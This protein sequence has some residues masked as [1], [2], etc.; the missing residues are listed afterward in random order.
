MGQEGLCHCKK[1]KLLVQVPLEDLQN[2]R[3]NKIEPD[4]A[5]DDGKP[6]EPDGFSEFREEDDEVVVDFQGDL[7]AA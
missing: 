7:S 1:G 4:G 3:R 5:D 2:K 6:E